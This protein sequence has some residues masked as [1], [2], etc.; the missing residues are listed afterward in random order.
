MYRKIQIKILFSV[1]QTKEQ[2]IGHTK[3]LLSTG[4]NVAGKIVSRPKS[5]K[6]LVM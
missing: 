5:A 2:Y 6:G 3:Q 4:Q 1:R